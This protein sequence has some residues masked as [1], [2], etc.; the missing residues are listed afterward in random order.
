MFV[1]AQSNCGTITS[2]EQM[3]KLFT[4]QKTLDNRP[5]LILNKT[6]KYVPIKVHIIGSDKGTGYYKLDL[7]LASICKINQDFAP[8]GVHFYIK[9]EIEYIN[10]TELNT[11][12]DNAIFSLSEGYKDNAAVNVFF[13]GSSATYCGV[14]YGGLDVVYIIN[15][16]QGL[17][18][19]TLTHELGH[20]FS[21]P[22]TFYGWENNTTPPLSNQE[23][24][25]GTNCRNVGDRFCDTK[26]DY[27]SYRWSCQSKLALTD[28]NGVQFRPDSTL[29]MNYAMDECHR[30][31]STEQ[32][33]AMDNNLTGRGIINNNL[34]DVPMT[35]PKL[36][37]PIDNDSNLNAKMVHLAWSKS[38]GAIGYEIQIARL[39]LW[40]SAYIT[41]I[42]KDTF[43]DAKLFGGWQFNWRVK[44]ISVTNVCGEYSNNNSFFAKDYPAS[45]SEIL[46]NKNSIKIYPN[47]SNKNETIK[48]ESNTNT[49]L[50]IYDINGKEIYNNNISKGETINFTAAKAGIYFAQFIFSDG[51]IS[52][53]IIVQ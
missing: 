4:F 49:T 39:K 24:I 33:A 32:F 20:F 15:T 27:F 41:T 11:T 17:N 5:L 23:K 31:F 25:D 12:T 22:H 46:L 45:T 13:A 6:I 47:P 50:F 34:V 19:T 3:D 35:M 1:N 44:P 48:I 53:K 21:L 10:N 9:D 38:E 29:F 28:P 51:K 30:R 42:V 2:K 8:I 26:P 16:C 40:E 43:Y 52:K 36:L 7:L 14:Y 18:A 37:Y